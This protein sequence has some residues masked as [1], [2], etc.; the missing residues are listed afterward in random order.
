MY[1]AEANNKVE[2][3]SQVPPSVVT[4]FREFRSKVI[5]R[6]VL[7]WSEHCTECVWPTCYTTCDLYRPREDGRC[8][9]FID[10]MV[11][12]DCQG[13]VNSYILKIRFNRWGKLWSPGNI[14][15]FPPEAASGLEHRDRQIASLVRLPLPK[16]LKRF[17]T[18]K[19]YN[20]KKWAAIGR[21]P[22]SE[23]PDLFVMECYN[24]QEWPVNLTLTFRSFN[25]GFP[26]PFQ[27]LIVVPSGFHREKIRI[28]EILS[29]LDLTA[30]FHIELVP[31]EIAD[32]TTIFF[33][34]IDFV[35]TGQIGA[36]KAGKLKCIVWDLDK[37]LWD[38]I[39]IEDGSENVRVKPGVVE[40]IR[41]L[42]RRGILHSIAS[43]NSF[44]DAMQILKKHNLDEYFLSPQISWGPKSESMRK[45]AQ[46]LNIG[47]D[48]L[49]MVDDSE[50]EL[51]EV[52]SACPTVRT[53]NAERY[54]ELLDMPECQVPVTAES[55]NRRV[56]YQQEGIRKSVAEGFAGDYLA[57]LRD[58]KMRMV[59][60]PLTESNIERV[61]ELTQRTNQ[62]N[63]SGNRYDREVLRNI[64]GDP[65][66]DTYVMECQ[67]RFG[68]YGIV[69]FSIVDMRE[70]RMTDLM[71]SCRIQ[72][73]RVEHAFL[74][75]IIKEHIAQTGSDFWANYRKTP[76]NA[77]AGRV[78]QDLGM[79]EMA[80]RDGITSLVFYKD[81]MIPNEGIVNIVR[82]DSLPVSA[83][84]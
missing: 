22:S 76:R 50:F 61:H 27:K 72:S 24:P 55:R 70:P 78:F 45:I 62:M 26:V 49:M 36:S 83:R 19:R 79:H 52:Q 32:G 46:S 67:D 38:G 25:P 84:K 68:S 64:M 10:G 73:K 82:E 65:N 69:G 37:T 8:R 14:Y 5:E 33:G 43:K 47:I 75:T 31:N 18:W 3:V 41:E 80:E 66:L 9:R 48:T 7:P 29:A 81:Q 40:V 35:R 58:C 44:D 59:L 57:F 74:T 13:A 56:M 11:R 42:D 54:H 39:L 4:K 51:A 12:V 21:K 53:L 20:L 15:L 28:D 1:E 77:Q 16:S 30:P 2:S 6:T 23:Y 71:F 60:R 63:F 34:L 17:V